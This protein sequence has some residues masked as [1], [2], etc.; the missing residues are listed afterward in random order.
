MYSHSKDLAKRTISG[1]I[2]C[3]KT[4]EIAR[5]CKYDVYQGALAGI[6]YH[7]FDMKTGS[8]AIVTSKVRVRVNEKLAEELHKATIKNSKRRKVYSR[9]KDSIWTKSLVEMRPLFSKNKNVTYLLCVVDV[10]TKYA[11]VKLLKGKK[12]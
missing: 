11:W 1:K 12:R 6:T 4:Y 7:F 3:N 10:S 9:F 2:L 8:E 5:N